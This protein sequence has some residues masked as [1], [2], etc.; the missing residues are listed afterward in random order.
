MKKMIMASLVGICAVAIVISFFMPWAKASTS[1]T[2]VAKGVKQSMDGTSF[3]AKIGKY[4]DVATQA[5]SGMGDI[6]V[7]TIVSGYDMPAMVHKKSSHVAVALAMVYVKDA[8]NLDTKVLLIYLVPLFALAC[9][10]LALLGLK[11]ILFVAIMGLV[12]GIISIVGFFKIATTDMSSMVV[13][14]SIEK[15]LWLTLWAY[16]VIFAISIVWVVIDRKKA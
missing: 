12:S 8:S 9:I 11:N 10:A 16:L 15:G 4:F 1:A 2:R 5:I 7:N 13:Q 3:G 6:N 14:I